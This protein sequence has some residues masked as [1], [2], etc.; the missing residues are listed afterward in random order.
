MSIIK[1]TSLAINHFKSILKE[2]N[3]KYILFGLK[4][5][6]CSGFEYIV[7][8]SDTPPQKN[9]ELVSIADVP[10]IICGKSLMYCMGTEIKWE[11]NMM[12][13]GLVF[14]NPLSKNTCGCGI[15]FKPKRM[16]FGD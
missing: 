13:E 4:S 10:I 9:D 7:E 3:A 6:G 8:P 2:R 11:K 12:G 5:G 15:S 1:V 16:A 14:N